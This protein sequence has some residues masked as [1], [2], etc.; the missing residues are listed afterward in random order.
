MMNVMVQVRGYLPFRYADIYLKLAGGYL[1]AKETYKADIPGEDDYDVESR[2]FAPFNVKI[3]AGCTFFFAPQ[4]ENGDI[5]LG[6][7]FD[8]VFTKPLK[9]ELCEDNDCEDGD[10]DDEDGPDDA[11]MINT[12]QLSVHFTWV[13]TVF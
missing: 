10:W 7:D 9:W 5:G 2:A 8:Y 13:F 4:S 11:D 12:F 6:L 1:S 3:G